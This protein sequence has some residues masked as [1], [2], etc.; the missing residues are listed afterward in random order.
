MEPLWLDED[1]LEDVLLSLGVR[2]VSI[3][4]AACFSVLWF[5]RRVNHLFLVIFSPDNHILIII[6]PLTHVILHLEILGL[7]LSFS[8]QDLQV[9]DGLVSL[10]EISAHHLDLLLFVTNFP[11]HVL[12]D[13]LTLIIGM[14][15]LLQYLCFLLLLLKLFLGDGCEID[16][17]TDLDLILHECR[18]PVIQL[19]YSLHQLIIHANFVLK[20]ST[21]PII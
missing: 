14:D 6:C 11:V 1:F 16:Q 5:A 2:F 21:I 12:H 7:V 19:L 15:P 9:G 18:V 3:F 17:L 20:S 8:E 4:A 13:L 10:V